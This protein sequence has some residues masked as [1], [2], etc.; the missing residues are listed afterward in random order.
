MAPRFIQ[1]YYNYIEARR[2]ENS[3]KL[4]NFVVRVVFLHL[5]GF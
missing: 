5:N 3:F 1:S 4:P 2:V